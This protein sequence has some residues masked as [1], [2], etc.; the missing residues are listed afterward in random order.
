M[1]YRHYEDEAHTDPIGYSAGEG[2]EFHRAVHAAERADAEPAVAVPQ[3]VGRS[4]AKTRQARVANTR[5]KRGRIVGLVLGLVLLLALAGGGYYVFDRLTGGPAAPEDFAAGSQGNSVVV[6]VHA[7]DTAEQ[8]GA[9]AVEKGVVASSGAF[10][11]AAVQ[12]TSIASVQPG[13]YLLPSRVPATQAVGALV[14]PSARV[15]SVVI[16]E[17]RQ[18]HDSRDVNTGAV[19]KGI[20]TLLS[21]ASCI[22]TTGGGSPTCISYE[23]FDSAGGVDD[24]SALGVPDWAISQVRGVPDRDRQLEGLI[25]AGSWDFDPTASPSDV[26]GQLVSE[27]AATYESTG[28]LDA[29]T[30]SGL[31]PYQTLVAASLVERES[32][33]ADFS[34][35]A[36]VIVNRLAAPQKLEFDSTVNYALDT[37]E[38]A[39]TDADRAA[40]TPWNTYAMEGLPATPIAAPSVGA[41]EAVESPAE[42]DWLYFVTINQAGNTLFTRDYNEHLANIGKVEDGFLESGR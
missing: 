26:L 2:S 13:F 31:D 27:S 34:K 20:Y 12:N 40:V 32:L 16:S 17:G 39:T 8:I 11:G 19:K 24:P 7:G 4:R 38:V 41:V 15:G 9:E 30:K 22:D 29:G 36:R 10:M 5:R 33:P 25:A 35:V 23:D 14:D 3:E 28:I 1:S 37:T 21:E 6:R 42:G 18:L